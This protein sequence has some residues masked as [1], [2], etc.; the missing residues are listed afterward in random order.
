MTD[1]PAR[2]P[3]IEYLHGHS[4]RKEALTARSSRIFAALAVSCVL[5]G[6]LLAASS[7]TATAGTGYHQPAPG[8]CHEITLKHFYAKS[9]PSK[10][11]NCSGRHTSRTLVSK[12]LRGKVNWKAPDVFRPIWGTCLRKMLRVLGGNDKARSMS[13]YSASFYIPTLR[14]RARGAK[15]LRCDISLLGG[16]TLQ[17]LPQKLAL[18][19]LPLKD[20]FLQ[21][22]RGPLSNLRQTVC[23]KTHSIRATG[24]FKVF[25]KTYPGPERFARLAA[26]RCPKLTTTRSWLYRSPP[27]ADMWRVGYRTIV[28]FS[29]TSK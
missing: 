15:W 25:S 24:A 9:A 14:E 11:V 8:S 23:S 17:P 18:G 19:R 5:V 1:S 7:T 3:C 21:C 29:K 2:W 26:R 6:S 12:R 28:C 22:A 4:L 10:S 13:A 27:S 20:K 16:R